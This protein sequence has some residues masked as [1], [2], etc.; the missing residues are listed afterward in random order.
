MNIDFVKEFIDFPF[1]EML[2]IN[3]NPIINSYEY[4]IQYKEK[5]MQYTRDQY[6]KY[7]ISSENLQYIQYK[8]YNKI[9]DSKIF[10]TILDKNEENT[11]KQIIK[12]IIFE[13]QK[14]FNNFF[15]YV[16]SLNDNQD[17]NVITSRPSSIRSIR[18]IRS[19]KSIKSNIS[20]NFTLK[21]VFP[22]IWKT[23]S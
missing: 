2:L 8:K 9:S 6:D 12:N 20:S 22:K 5:Y 15:Q 4:Y 14:Y 7:R 21:K 19:K 23:T 3:N 10:I 11:L 18:S 17:Q 16:K 1:D 13:Q